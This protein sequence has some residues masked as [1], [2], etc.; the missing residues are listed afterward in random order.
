MEIL[1]EDEHIVAINKPHGLL[2]HRSEIAR[3][4]TEFAVQMLR[5]FC[6]VK[7][8]PAH[9]LDRKTSGVLLFAKNPE[10]LRALNAQFQAKTIEK[11]YMTI[12]RGHAEGRGSIDYALQNEAGKIQDAVTDFKLLTKFEI[13]FAFG[14]YETSRYSL[15]EV[16]PLT[17]RMHQIRRHLAH[18][19]HPILGDRPHGC[20]KQNKLWKENWDMTKMML[21]AEVLVFDHP[22]SNNR[23]KIHAFKSAEFERVLSIL[24]PN[25]IEE[26][27]STL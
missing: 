22:Y 20:N 8:Y 6:G 17:G 5:E 21:H 16:T 24:Q 23:Q 10:M 7:V 11:T 2:V 1:F 26:T 12:V 13:P 4:A 19:R 15:L 18:L 27:H 3:D 9:R 25:R 14:K